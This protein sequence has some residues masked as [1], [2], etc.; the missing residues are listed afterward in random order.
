[1]WANGTPTWQKW[2]CILMVVGFV[3]GCFYN[4]GPGA[5]GFDPYNLNEYTQEEKT[6]MKLCREID[7]Y[8]GDLKF[9]RNGIMK[10]DIASQSKLDLGPDRG[11]HYRCSIIVYRSIYVENAIDQLAREALI[12]QIETHLKD[13][14]LMIYRGQKGELYPGGSYPHRLESFNNLIRVF[15]LH[16]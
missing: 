15:K 2:A 14:R 6:Y 5:T 11:Q 12:P 1:M 16:R 8:V 7:H 9:Y 3:V 4:M 10:F 13:T